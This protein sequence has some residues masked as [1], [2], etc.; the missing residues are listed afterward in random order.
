MMFAVLTIATVQR[1]GGYPNG[2][3]RGDRLLEAYGDGLL[4]T[5]TSTLPTSGSHQSADGA[6]PSAD[7]G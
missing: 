2:F 3:R 7:D 5:S 6:A 1:V 4:N